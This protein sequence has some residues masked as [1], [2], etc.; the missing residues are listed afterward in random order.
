M[1]QNFDIGP[2]F[3][4]MKCRTM[5]QKLPLSYILL[6]KHTSLNKR[7]IWAFRNAIRNYKK[8]SGKLNK[9]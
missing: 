4:S 7:K 2:S 1:S 6:V 8:N 9:Q 5:H 3:Y